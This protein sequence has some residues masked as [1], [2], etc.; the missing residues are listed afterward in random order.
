MFNYLIVDEIFTIFSIKNNPTF[1]VL[2][3][4]SSLLHFIF[5]I[6]NN[7]HKIKAKISFVMNILN[8]QPLMTTSLMIMMMEK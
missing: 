3:I 8:K 1:F 4:S 6:K 5:F 2:F 7:F